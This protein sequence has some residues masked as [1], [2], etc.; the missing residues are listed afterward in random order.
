[1]VTLDMSILR[2]ERSKLLIIPSRTEVREMLTRPSVA[3][4]AIICGTILALAA[5]AGVITLAVTGN[6]T[7]VIGT[8][9][10]G[11]LVTLLVALASRLKAMHE[12]IRTAAA[13][14]PPP[15][16]EG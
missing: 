9:I 3:I 15:P 6:D 16:P 4:T 2:P 1:M 14:T 11:P 7:A 12:T 8:L 10:G 5:I 13:T